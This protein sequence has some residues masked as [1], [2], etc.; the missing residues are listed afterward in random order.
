MSQVIQLHQRR[1]N[2]Q[3]FAI[4]TAVLVALLLMLLFMKLQ[5]PIIEDA[6]SGVMID[7]GDNKE[8]LGD[9]NTREAGGPSSSPQKTVKA[10]PEPTPPTP[11]PKPV[12]SSSPVKTPPNNTVVSEDPN[13]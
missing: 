6:I 3:S 4:T 2:Q 12:K 7:F 11:T 10:S 9:D 1:S 8:G 13:A 5:H